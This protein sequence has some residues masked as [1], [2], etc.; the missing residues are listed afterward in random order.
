MFYCLVIFNGTKLLYVS[1]IE[2]TNFEV[3][4]ENQITKN[5][6]HALLLTKQRA[7]LYANDICTNT[8]YNIMIMPINKSNLQKFKKN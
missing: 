8:N 5:N 4:S 6:A 2:G 3:V 1:K 7:F